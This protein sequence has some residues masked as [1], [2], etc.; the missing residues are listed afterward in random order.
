MQESFGR[1]AAEAAAH[2]GLLR[3]GRKG[4]LKH[5]EIFKRLLQ[6]YKRHLWLRKEAKKQTGR[7]LP[8]AA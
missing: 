5:W 2:P 4:R 3:R 7:F 6:G 8:A 1:F